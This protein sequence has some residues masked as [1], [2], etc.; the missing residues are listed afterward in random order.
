MSLAEQEKEA[1][2]YLAELRGKGNDEDAIEFEAF[3]SNMVKKVKTKEALLSLQRTV[4]EFV[5]DA[6]LQIAEISR[7]IEA[8][9]F[10]KV[11]KINNPFCDGTDSC[12]V[13]RPQSVDL[14]ISSVAMTL[15]EALREEEGVYNKRRSN[16]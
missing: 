10:L 12:S 8:A 15:K 6:R 13:C 1:R 5:F 4:G 2:E 14:E 11:E 7:S 16:Y 3:L 9:K